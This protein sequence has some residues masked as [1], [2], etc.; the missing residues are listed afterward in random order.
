MSITTAPAPRRGRPRPS[1]TI[2]RDDRI[3]TLLADGPLSRNELAAATG[4]EKSIVYLALA[5]LRTAGRI[6][7]CVRDG[8]IVWAHA[9]GTPCP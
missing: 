7:Q 8:V 9:D 5:R 1:E 4:L 6:R 3:Y 2:S